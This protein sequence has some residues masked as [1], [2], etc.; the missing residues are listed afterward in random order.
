[1]DSA[2]FD[3][4]VFDTGIFDV[5]GYVPATALDIVTDALRELR[6][7][8]ATEPAS[9][10]DAEF[11]LSRLNTI[12]DEWNAK[13]GA[14][15]A[16][17]LQSYTL[18]AGVSPH[19]IGPSGHFDVTLRPVTI[20]ELNLVLAEGTRTPITVHH[21]IEWWGTR[22]DPASATGDPTDVAYEPDWPL[23]KLYFY[24]VPDT[25][26]A[27]EL[28]SRVLL[29]GVTLATSMDLPPAYQRALTLTLAEDLSA[30]FGVELTE[31]TVRKA[32]RARA[33]VQAN[34]ARP[35]DIATRDS[36]MPGGDTIT[37]DLTRGY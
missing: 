31:M 20:L 30:P 11:G 35:A 33:L 13:R 1:M 24:P 37:T 2:V 4:D 8:N 23:G 28:Y 14:I 5:G 16:D 7:L 21:G 6:I 27:V 29:S 3:A 36:G 22:S 34:N 9:G 15:Y 18:Q 12:L 19:L 25:A 26:L 17:T 10:D 32:A